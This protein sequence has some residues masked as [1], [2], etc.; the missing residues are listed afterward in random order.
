MNLTSPFPRRLGGRLFVLLAGALVAASASADLT[1]VGRSSVAA[2]GMP[3]ISQEKLSIKKDWLR[4]DLIDRG[5]SY[6]YVFD[7]KTRDILVIDHAFRTA[8]LHS[9]AKT[10]AGKGK[11]D[12]PAVDLDLAKTGRRQSVRH[13][14]CEEHSVQGAMPTQLGADPVVFHLRGNVWIAEK[15]PEQK[16]MEALRKAAESSSFLLG[17]P[18]MAGM[19]SDQTRALG[20][21]I[22]Q[23]VGK[24]ILCGLDVE[25]RYEGSGRMVDLARKMA[26]RL[27]IVYDDFSTEAIDAS[28]FAVPAGYRLIK[29]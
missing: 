10:V 22:R 19:Q 14:S 16:E 7:L 5:R 6:T 29:K 3:S 4:R 26:S 15:A 28:A 24:G 18:E 17:L 20:D 25:T 2:L 27:R 1:L 21:S 8:E 11:T 9:M 13:W 23:L 12:K